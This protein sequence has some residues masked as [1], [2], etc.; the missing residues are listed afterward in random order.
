MLTLTGIGQPAA[1]DPSTQTT[2]TSKSFVPSLS[3]RISALSPLSPTPVKTA[4]APLIQATAPP[5]PAC[6]YGFSENQGVC[7]SQGCIDGKSDCVVLDANG[8]TCS[9]DQYLANWHSTG[10]QTCPTPAA[11][12]SAQPAP[13]IIVGPPPPQYV[14]TD[15]SV[16]SDPSM[17]PQ[18]AA[19][20]PAPQQLFTC[21]DG[22]LVGDPAIC[23][24]AATAQPGPSSTDMPGTVLP[25]V[26]PTITMPTFWTPNMILGVGAIATLAAALLAYK[27]GGTMRLV[28]GIG[29]VGVGGW[30]A[31]KAAQFN[32]L[33]PMP[34]I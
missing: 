21:P 13:Q 11:T 14:C 22:S 23:Q 33:I 26:L 20:Q 4:T 34:T 28:A 30:T 12:P 27:T 31:Y 10:A 3:T 5:P 29:A 6:P 17:C 7:V 15:N 2:T 18:P 1:L 32:G 16:V 8:A 24:Q 9:Y 19:S 25:P